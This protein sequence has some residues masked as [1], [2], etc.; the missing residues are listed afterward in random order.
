MLPGGPIPL[1]G[2][3]DVVHIVNSSTGRPA[4]FPPTE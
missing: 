1:C 3:G 2:P 4:F